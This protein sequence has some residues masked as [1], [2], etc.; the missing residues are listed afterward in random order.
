M[1]PRRVER[2]E[3]VDL[4]FRVEPQSGSEVHQIERARQTQGDTD[5][6]A[7]PTILKVARKLRGAG[8]ERAVAQMAGAV[9]QVLVAGLYA[10]AVAIPKAIS[11]SPPRA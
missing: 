2:H 10:A 6:R 3:P 11:V 5:L 1:L 7:D 4:A 9:D 8:R